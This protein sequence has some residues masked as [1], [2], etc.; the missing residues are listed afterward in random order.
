MACASVT[1]MDQSWKTARY[2]IA[3]ALGLLA[4][5]PLKA[6]REHGGVRPAG[7]RARRIPGKR[8]CGPGRLAG[9]CLPGS[10]ARWSFASGSRRKPCR[11]HGNAGIPS[12]ASASPFARHD[13]PL[14]RPCSS[15]E[16]PTRLDCRPRVSAIITLAFP[17][18]KAGTNGVGAEPRRPKMATTVPDSHFD[19][20]PLRPHC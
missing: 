11:R 18:V 8:R 6:A 4:R 9:A 5:V 14:Q 16:S 7:C 19:V 1:N 12:R 20:F 13:A 15:V 17:N 3:V 2:R 10:N